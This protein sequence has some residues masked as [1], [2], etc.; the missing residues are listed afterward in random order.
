LVFYGVQP[1]RIQR[2]IYRALAS[3]GFRERVPEGAYAVAWDIWIRYWNDGH[4]NQ[5]RYYQLSEGDTVVE[6]GAYIGYYTLKMSQA[7]GPRGHVIAIEPVEENRQ[8]IL[9]NIRANHIQNVTVLPY[10]VWNEKGS[11]VFHRANRQK[12]SLSL[13]SL[14]GKGRIHSRTVPTST[15]DEIIGETSISTPD[16]V[17]ITVNGVEVE[18]LQG[19]ERTLE[20]GTNLVIAAKYVIDGVPTYERVTTLLQEKGYQ[21]ILDRY[22]F[23]KIENPDRHAVVYAHK[24]K[25]R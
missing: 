14:S 21:V 11:R 22:G 1:D 9:E 19:M 15:I 25:S 8:I 16:L 23:T 5:Q 10:A 17:I 20:K 7:V 12:N 24:K 6:A 2:I 4:I 3:R 18:A 13:Q